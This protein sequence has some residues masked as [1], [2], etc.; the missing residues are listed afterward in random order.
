MLKKFIIILALIVLPLMASADVI[1][2]GQKYVGFCFELSGTNRYSEYTFIGVPSLSGEP[3]VIA[4]GECASFYKFA[5]VRIMAI[6]NTSFDLTAFTANPANYIATQTGLISSNISIPMESQTVHESNP[7][8]SVKAIYAITN[9]AGSTVTLEKTQTVLTNA[10]GTTRSEI[11]DPTGVITNANT[12]TIVPANTNNGGN[13]GKLST[14]EPEKQDNNTIYYILI[15]AG[16][17]V[18][19]ALI[20]LLR[21]K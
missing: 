17:G 11:I 5:T 8:A 13:A 20:L 4:A 6:K 18:L 3:R 12:N 21:K 16:G 2:P 7:L 19:I 9:L 14:T 15:P 10:D 1:E